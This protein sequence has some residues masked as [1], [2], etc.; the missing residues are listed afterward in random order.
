[1]EGHFKQRQ[2]AERAAKSALAGAPG[3]ALW[4]KRPTKAG[5]WVAQ[6]G[7]YPELHYVADNLKTAGLWVFHR[8]FWRKPRELQAAGWLQILAPNTRIT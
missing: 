7:N 5:W 8:G 4:R 1:M 6:V 3:S 2:A